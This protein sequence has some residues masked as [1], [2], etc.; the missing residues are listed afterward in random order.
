MKRLILPCLAL[1]ALLTSCAATEKGPDETEKAQLAEFAAHWAVAFNS[2]DFDT[3]PAYYAE[4]LDFNGK[5]AS[6]QAAVQRMWD[7][8][9]EA[10]ELTL[11]IE[12]ASWQLDSMRGKIYAG[13]LSGMAYYAGLE[14]S[15]ETQ[16]TLWINL[17]EE[18]AP[19]STR[20]A[21]PI[22]L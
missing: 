5:P 18:Y 20:S 2:R 16:I 14:D 4:Q 17:P 21:R 10:Y 15:M 3:L 1:L 9:N 12:P 8:L 22:R 7:F 11:H 6:G 19:T 13:H